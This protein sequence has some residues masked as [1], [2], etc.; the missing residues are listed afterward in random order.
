[1]PRPTT[2]LQSGRA[3]SPGSA[4]VQPGQPHATRRGCLRVRHDG[5]AHEWAGTRPGRLAGCAKLTASAPSTV[6]P[7]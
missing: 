7:P 5:D 2:R 4:T 3:R 1:M 6:R